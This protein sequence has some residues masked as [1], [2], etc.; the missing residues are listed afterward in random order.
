MENRSNRQLRPGYLKSQSYILLFLSSLFFRF[1]GG[2][3]VVG[4]V[5]MVS[6]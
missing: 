3:V 1:I 4:P 6:L 5:V 2:H